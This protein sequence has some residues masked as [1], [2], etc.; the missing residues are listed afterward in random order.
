MKYA[1]IVFWAAVAIILT[2]QFLHLSGDATGLLQTVFTHVLPLLSGVL[3]GFLAIVTAQNL[4]PGENTSRLVS[5]T[6]LT[7]VAVSA[8]IGLVTE[9][10]SM[11]R[12]GGNASWLEA[13]G[14]LVPLVAL[15]AKIGL[16]MLV[17]TLIKSAPKTK[18]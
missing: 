14:F 13:A 6:L 4:T 8:A 5:S 16:G 12:R 3:L 17:A 10:L 18:S 15:S 9:L 11:Q 7:A 2:F 1:Q